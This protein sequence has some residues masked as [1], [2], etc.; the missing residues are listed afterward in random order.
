MTLTAAVTNILNKEVTEE[1]AKQFALDN[2]GIL[3][4][5]IKSQVISKLAQ[6]GYNTVQKH[7]KVIEKA[8]HRVNLKK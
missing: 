5:Y 7:N 4:A 3:A 6:D 2:F 8:K 1:Q